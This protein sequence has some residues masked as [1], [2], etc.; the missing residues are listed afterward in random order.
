MYNTTLFKIPLFWLFF[1]C[2]K[3]MK[4]NCKDYISLIPPRKHPVNFIKRPHTGF[5][6]GSSSQDLQTLVFWESRPV[7]QKQFLESVVHSTCHQRGQFINGST[8]SR[9]EAMVARKRRKNGIKRR[10]RPRATNC[11]PFPRLHWG[12][13]WT[14]PY[15]RRKFRALWICHSR[16]CVKLSPWVIPQRMS[17]FIF[18]C[19]P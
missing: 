16:P 6:S 19:W 10:R 12:H 3:L 11:S 2:Y 7:T 14:Q 17:F 15:P 5:I 9:L 1:W 8:A 13:T 4:K 18:G